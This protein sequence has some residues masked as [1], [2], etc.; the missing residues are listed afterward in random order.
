[1][2][3]QYK[4]EKPRN[5]QPEGLR[6]R[7]R[8]SGIGSDDLGRICPS[9]SEE[10]VE[11]A[12]E[13]PKFKA[14][15]TPNGESRKRKAE[16]ALEDAGR[17]PEKK[18]SKKKKV[19][20]ESEEVESVTE[21]KKSKNKSKKGDHPSSDALD[22]APSQDDANVEGGKREKKKKKAKSE[23]GVGS[24]QTNGDAATSPVKAKKSKKSK[25]KKSA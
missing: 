8:P 5:V 17:S 10:D 3:Y 12:S 11:L 24:S 22:V 2:K 21:K 15:P 9:D 19:K 23:G 16:Q 14:P 6:M 13:T 18:K 25:E 7:Y 20:E 1:M 4:K